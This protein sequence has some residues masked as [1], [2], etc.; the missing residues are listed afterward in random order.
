MLLI[1]I[2]VVV[3]AIIIV[4]GRKE[5]EGWRGRNI[6][7]LSDGYLRASIILHH[8]IIK[9]WGIEVNVFCF[10]VVRDHGYTITVVIIA[11]VRVTTTFIISVILG[12]VG[13]VIVVIV[14][15]IGVHSLDGGGGFRNRDSLFG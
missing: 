5:G 15:I 6:V 12:V 4:S 7:G 9:E 3:A 2:C 13:V 11:D 14:S 8:V 10:E 1:I